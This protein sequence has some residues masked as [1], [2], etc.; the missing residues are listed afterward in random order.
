[1]RTEIFTEKKEEPLK[2]FSGK[3]GE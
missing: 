3:T 2:R 1:M